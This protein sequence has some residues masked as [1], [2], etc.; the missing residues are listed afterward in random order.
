MSGRTVLLIDGDRDTL[1][2]YS[3][4]L[5]HVGFRVL[6]A[7]D[8][9]QGAVMAREYQPDLVIL[10][11]FLQSAGE[12]SVTEL[13]RS[14]ERTADLRLLLVTAIPNLLKDRET[15]SERY[16]VKPC[17]PRMLL[18]EVLR[19]LDAPLLGAA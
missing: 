2:I 8:A 17:Q 18:A 4:I 7:M 1:V 13:L 10:E 5:E 14:D 9:E 15:S 6:Q 11:P 3:L 19:R 12:V 16:L